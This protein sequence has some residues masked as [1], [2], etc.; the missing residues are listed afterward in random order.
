MRGTDCR[1]WL[2]VAAKDLHSGTTFV[3]SS[4]CRSPVCSGQDAVRLSAVFMEP[5]HYSRNL[6]H[7]S[8]NATE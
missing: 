6:H 8:V 5:H 1:S 4:Y 2:P 3:D 7:A